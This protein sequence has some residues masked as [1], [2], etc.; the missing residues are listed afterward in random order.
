MNIVL[1]GFMGCGKTT[2]GKKIARYSGL[3]FIDMDKYIED[4]EKMT[5]SQI[6]AEKGEDYFRDVEHAA[7]LS[8]AKKDNCVIASG[9]GALTFSR[10]QEAFAGCTIVF[11]NT[12]LSV[13]QHRLRNDTKRPLL[14]SGDADKLFF[15]RRPQYFKA[16]NLVVRGSLPPKRVAQ[17]IIKK[18]N[19][20]N[21]NETAE[22]KGD[23]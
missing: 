2:V 20:E 21:I 8:L 7:C 11:I 15:K 18:L 4:K 19:L 5:V 14:K 6:F 22:L 16:A 1:C 12:P 10:N 9:G 17:N 13:I 23:M 3:S